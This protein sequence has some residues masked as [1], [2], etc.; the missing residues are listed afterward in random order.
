VPATSVSGKTRHWYGNAD[1]KITRETSHS[2]TQQPL[3]EAVRFSAFM[4]L[5]VLGLTG[6][7]DSEVHTVD[8]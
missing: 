1:L 6:S 8:A 2:S 3:C 4:A 5:L 7:E